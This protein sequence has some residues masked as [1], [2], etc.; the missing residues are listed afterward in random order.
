LRLGSMP[1]ALIR[2]SLEKQK[3]TR[4]TSTDWK[5]YGDLAEK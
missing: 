3:L 5:F 2:L 1:V 4:D